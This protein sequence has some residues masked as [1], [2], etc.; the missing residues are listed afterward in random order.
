MEPVVGGARVANDMWRDVQLR[1]AQRGG[2]APEELL[3]AVE[4]QRREE[5]CSFAPGGPSQGVVVEQPR[6]VV[7][8]VMADVADH[9]AL[10]RGARCAVAG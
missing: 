4:D 6:H 7:E 9:D 3:V 2:A 1:P 5:L 8:P 10:V